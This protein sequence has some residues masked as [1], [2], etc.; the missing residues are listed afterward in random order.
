MQVASTSGDKER[1]VLSYIVYSDAVLASS[2]VLYKQS[3][4]LFHS[5]VSNYIL[6]YAVDY[7]A[8]YNKAP[9]DELRLLPAEVYET[10][11]DLS[12]RL[13]TVV[14]AL[15]KPLSTNAERMLSIATTYFEKVQMELFVEVLQSKL[16]RDDVE[17]CVQSIN[18][19]KRISAGVSTGVNPI[20][21]TN[22]I[23]SVFTDTTYKSLLTFKDD[24]ASAFFGDTFSRASFVVINASEKA[25]KSSLL[26]DF[27]LRAVRQGLKVAYFEAGDMSQ[28]QV[29]R[30]IYQRITGHPRRA[31]TI[32]YP[33]TFDVQIDDYAKDVPIEVTYKDKKFSTDLTEDLVLRA[34]EKWKLDLSETSWDWKFSAHPQDLSVPRICTILDEWERTDNFIPDFVIVDYADILVPAIRNVEFRHQIND[35][36]ARLRGLSLDRNCCLLTATQAN[37]ASWDA[38][39][40]TRQHLSEDKRKAAHPTAMLGLSATQSEREMQVAKLNYLIRRDDVCNEMDQLYVAQCLPI[41]APMI[42]FCYP[43]YRRALATMPEPPGPV[44]VPSLPQK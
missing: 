15:S 21:D 42:R 12:D 23:H 31:G 17:S 11:I 43:S 18:Q 9:G 39:V 7:Y 4:R 19:F 10:D 24:D 26:I 8:K 30:R 6:K 32:R 28:V 41:C 29:F 5:D 25:G 35:T 38:A 22:V 34:C 33:K 16:I 2:V 37:A 27:A 14:E 40:M 20:T 1:D 13:V 36:F 44:I 3:P